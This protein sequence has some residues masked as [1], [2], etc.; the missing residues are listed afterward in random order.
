[1]NDQ[2]D[3][4]PELLNLAN[5]AISNKS[6]VRLRFAVT[7]AEYV[8]IREYCLKLDGCFYARLKGVPLVIEE[9]ATAPQLLL[10]TA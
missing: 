6:W 10:E 7:P 1:M 3:I 4:I 8:A 2:P 9:D 5:A